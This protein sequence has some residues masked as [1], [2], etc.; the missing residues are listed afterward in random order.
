MARVKD[1]FAQRGGGANGSERDESPPGAK[2]A[3]QEE[4]PEEKHS[5]VQSFSEG[6]SKSEGAQFVSESLETCSKQLLDVLSDISPAHDCTCYSKPEKSESINLADSLTRGASSTDIPDNPL[7]SDDEPAPADSQNIN[8][9][10]SKAEERSQKQ[11]MNYECIS[12]IA[13]EPA[14]SVISAVSSRSLVRQTN[15]FTFGTVVAP[16]Y[17][18]VFGRVGS[19]SQSSGDWGNPVRATLNVGDLTQSYSHTERRESSCTVPTDGG[20]NND[21]VQGNVIKAQES[22]QESL[23]V[24]PNSPPT[25]EGDTCLSVQDPVEIIHSDTICPNTI[26][27]DTVV[28]LHT[29][30]ISN[31]DLLNPQ[32]PSESLHLQGEAQEDNLTHD[33]QS[34]TTAGTAQAP[35]PEHTQTQIKANLDE[36]LAQLQTQKVMTSLETSIMSLQPSQSV[37]ERISDE[38]DQQTSDSGDNDCKRVDE[39]NKDEEVGKTVTTSTTTVITEEDILLEALHTT[40]PTPLETQVDTNNVEEGNNEENKSHKDE[41]IH[42]AEIKVIDEVAGSVTGTIMSHNHI[43]VVGLKDEAIIV[44]E[45]IEHREMEAAVIKQEDICLA[46]TTD[47]K[48]WEMM[49]EEEEKNILTGEDEREVIRLKAEDI[50]AVVDGQGEQLEDAEIETASDNRD[51]TEKEKEK[52]EDKMVGE[53]TAAREK[54]STA[55]DADVLEDKQRIGEGGI[56][57]IVARKD[58]EEIEKELQFNRATKTEKTA[59]EEEL[60]EET[61]LGKREGQ[62]ET[63]LEKEKHFAEIHKVNIKKIN[64]REEEQIEGEEE[65]EIDLNSDNEASVEW[66]NQIQNVEEENPDYKEDILVDETGESEMVD[67]SES[68]SI[69]DRGDEVERFEERL[70]I[71]PNKAEDSYCALVNNVQ[72][73]RVIDKENTGEGQ[74]AHIA[75]EMHLYQEEHF[76]SKDNVTHDLSEDA[77][78]EK[79]SAA[80]EGGSCV[81]A[82]EP[83][84]DQMSHDS[85]ESDSDDEVE[86]YMHCLRAVHTGAQAHKDR[87]KSTAF[88]AG[89]RPSVSRSKL[90]ST[91]MPSISESLDEEQPLSRLQDNHEDTE[92]ADIPPTAAALPASSGQESINRNVSWWIE[93]FSCNNISKTLLYAALLVVFVVLAY[94]Y[95]FLACFG[96]YLISVVWLCCQ[97]ERQPVKNNNRIG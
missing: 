28:H 86:L 68:M 35:L 13:A 75:T 61:E 12:N 41:K 6:S 15:S 92:T 76:Q 47:V 55:E 96:L 48:N 14:D 37:S 11:D 18:Q 21:N 93:T 62:Q 19:E 87:S 64:V 85:A 16:L 7:H 66:D 34:Q 88:N 56:E 51:T 63:E 73:K 3:A 45:K 74:N 32:I 97:G 50:E 36:T 94:H 43:H 4:T 22:N 60:T 17:H 31:P 42:S 53:I 72:D 5:D 52:T 54:E 1:Y 9:S 90:L 65:M 82:D 58:R 49:V 33:P 10:V 8:E 2:Q 38:T 26:S 81:F 83:E 59:G 79:E 27:G 23:D 71:T 80:A 44:S 20:G 78:D 91:P 57:V 46:D 40:P 69:E 24:T 67:Q 25:E 77:R 89:K 29:V 95:D 39:S 84:R 30:T 70:D